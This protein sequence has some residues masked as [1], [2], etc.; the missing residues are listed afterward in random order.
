VVFCC[1]FLL[2]ASSIQAQVHVTKID[3]AH[4]TD[5]IFKGT[6]ITYYLDLELDAEKL[7]QLEIFDCE[8]TET[9]RSFRIIPGSNKERIFEGTSELYWDGHTLS[10]RFFVSEK[11]S[12]CLVIKY[13]TT[14]G[15]KPKTIDL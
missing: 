10:I 5:T 14:K 11:K 6:V 2:A 1:F 8:S 7:R 9:V 13:W 3:T 12:E 15:K 4:S